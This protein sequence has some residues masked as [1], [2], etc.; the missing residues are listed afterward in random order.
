MYCTSNSCADLCADHIPFR[1]TTSPAAVLLLFYRLPNS[2]LRIHKFLT[3]TLFL[4]FF[5]QVGISFPSLRR[6]LAASPTA[7]PRVQK[8]TTCRPP[9]TPTYGQRTEPRRAGGRSGRIPPHEFLCWRPRSSSRIGAPLRPPRRP[10]PSIAT[11]ARRPPREACVAS[12]HR[13][14]P[15]GPSSL[16][17]SG[18][19]PRRR[20][21]SARALGA[22]RRRRAATAASPLDPAAP[23]PQW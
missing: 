4:F 22:A 11:A 12:L 3:R 16:T 14:L 21:T 15:L 23:S 13:L 2:V 17:T 7:Y 1:R 18:S 8:Q 10:L 5:L 20:S 19:R 6:T 9:P